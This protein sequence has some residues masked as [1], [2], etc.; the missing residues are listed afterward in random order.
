MFNN[1]K[2][3]RSGGAMNIYQ[4]IIEV[5][6]LVEFLQ[7]DTQ[8]YQYRYVS[9]SNVLS[10]IRPKMD[11]LGL[12]LATDVIEDRQDRY[13]WEG[14]DSKGSPKQI[15]QFVTRQKMKKIW[16]NAEK[17]DEK[18]SMHWTA[19]GE[20]E[21]PAKADGKAHTYGERYYLL[22][23]FNI[24]TDNEDPDAF[25]KKQ[26]KAGNV[27]MKDKPIELPK[28]VGMKERVL[29]TGIAKFGD[30]DKFK[31]WRVDNNLVEDL[32]KATDVQLNYTLTVLREY[33][34]V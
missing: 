29:G 30:A 1:Y 20:D 11:E 21:D 31:T 28:P 27:P 26:E 23:F 8:G 6:K 34:K 15:I 17:P 5:R 2:N 19:S 12:I 32:S 7:K 13:Q 22:K 25:Q 24:P 18:F 3:R 14:K 9:G 10:S 33:K 4:K 16:I